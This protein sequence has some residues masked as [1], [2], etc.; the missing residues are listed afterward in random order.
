M[1]TQSILSSSLKAA[2]N[3]PAYRPRKQAATQSLPALITKAASRQTYY[4]IRFLVDRDRV[5]NAYRAYAYFRWLDDR[6][7]QEAL[8]QNE[9]VAFV[10]RQQRL[11]ND[12]YRGALRLGL[13]VEE[14]MLAD[15]IRSDD[16]PD[17]GLQAYIRHMMAV[18]TFDTYRQGKLTSEEA[19]VEYSHHLA[20]AV[21]EAMHYFIG[22]N[23]ASP[24]NDS[25]YL[26][27]TAAHITHMLRDTVDDL[28]AGYFN[29]PGEFLTAHRLNPGDLDDDSYRAWVK[30]RVEQARSCFAVGRSYLAQVKSLRCRLAGYAYMAR[31]EGV[32]DAIEREGYQLRADYPE[33]KQLRARLRL[34]WSVLT[35]TVRGSQ[36]AMFHYAGGK[37]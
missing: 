4:T 15:L 11:M 21:T 28:T 32:L 18:M 20:V 35:R 24:H 7:D 34:V 33:R 3:Y 29:I 5:L 1:A 13:S 19:L 17:S 12:C 2:W 9:R 25:R 10:E 23:A 14:Q 26:A 30:D 16:A 37:A 31:F 8:T 6:L 36:P 22:H 27:V